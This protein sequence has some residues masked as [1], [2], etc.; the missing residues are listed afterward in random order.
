MKVIFAPAYYLTS[1][2]ARGAQLSA[3]RLHVR[4]AVRAVVAVVLERAEAR[5]LRQHLET[6]GARVYDTRKNE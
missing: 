1:T 5:L 6:Y 2:R 3:T 4:A